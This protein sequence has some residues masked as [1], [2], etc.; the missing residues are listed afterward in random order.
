ML[1]H[2]SIQQ[3]SFSIAPQLQEQAWTCS[4]THSTRWA[5]WNSYINR[6]C[7]Q[8]VLPW[9]QTEINSQATLLFQDWERING[10]AIALGQKRLI[11]VP[12]LSI[13]RSEIRVPQF[14]VDNANHAGDYYFAIQ[15]DPDDAWI[16]IWGYTTHH[17]LKA[18]GEYDSRDRCYSLAMESL[19]LDIN[20][21][22][23]V[24]LLCPDE[25][26]RFE[27]QSV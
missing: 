22:S 26:T 23:V 21:F 1:A 8:S 7:L 18:I 3:P 14:W 2:F 6:I 24:Q 4:R 5:Q 27:A 25:P 12:D 20:V 11:L 19:I 15:V 16:Q 17:Q 9:L 10:S 13:D